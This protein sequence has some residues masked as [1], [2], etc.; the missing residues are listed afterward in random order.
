MFHFRLFWRDDAEKNIRTNRSPLVWDMAFSPEKEGRASFTF[1]S[2]EMNLLTVHNNCNVSIVKPNFCLFT[3]RNSLE[4]QPSQSNIF[5]LNWAHSLSMGVAYTWVFMI[6]YHSHNEKLVRC[7][8]DLLTC[9]HFVREEKKHPCQPQAQ[10]MP[11][12]SL[13]SHLTK[14]HRQ[15]YS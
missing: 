5:F 1:L 10:A 13:F 4:F 8:H 9:Y 7:H 6:Q 14:M 11:T 15:Y 2:K 12:P 3:T